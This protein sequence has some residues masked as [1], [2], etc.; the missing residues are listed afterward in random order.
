[1]IIKNELAGRVFRK[2]DFKREDGNT[3]IEREEE[4]RDNIIDD[5]DVFTGR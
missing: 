3:K 1:L 4:I 5:D 2:E